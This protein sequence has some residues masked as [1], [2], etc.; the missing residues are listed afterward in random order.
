MSTRDEIAAGPRWRPLGGALALGAL[1]LGATVPPVCLLLGIRVMEVESGDPPAADE[2]PAVAFGRILDRRVHNDR[3]DY[4]GFVAD[5]RE[6]STVVRSLGE[7]GPRTRPELFPSREDRLAY[8]INAYN[9][10]VLY[11]VIEHWPIA[12]V[13]DVRGPIEP[14]DG[15]G[16]FYGL[17]FRLDGRRTNL[18][19][20]ENDILRD[21]FEDARIHAAINCASISCPR[22]SNH[23]YR[24]ADLDAALEEATARFCSE[25][26][27]VVIDDA[28]RRFLLSAIFDWYAAD[29]ERDAQR[30]G[31]GATVL[32]FIVHHAEPEVAS[33]LRAGRQADY[34]IEFA[35]YDWRL[36]SMPEATSGSLVSAPR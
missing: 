18:Y 32:D 3:L 2:L 36:N 25:P 35:P 17:H 15:F 5:R 31:D 12:S 26:P 27:H 10:L 19:D 4:R 28:G 13:H 23:P 33:R 8:Y 22:L 9:A 1:V 14:A 21:H 30:A 16:F 20:L 7:V 24:S 29:F 6:L 34:R 11:G